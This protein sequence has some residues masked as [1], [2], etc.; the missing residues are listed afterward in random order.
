MNAE[1]ERG[2]AQS[3]VYRYEKYF[4]GKRDKKIIS[5]RLLVTE[6]N[7]GRV[8]FMPYTLFSFNLV[9]YRQSIT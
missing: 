3:A 6:R 2:K 8:S 1:R 5:P 7:F 4:K 9:C